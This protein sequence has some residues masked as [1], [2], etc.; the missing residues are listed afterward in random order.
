[1]VQSLCL[2]LN[3]KLVVTPNHSI[4]SLIRPLFSVFLF[5]G[6]KKGLDQFTGIIRPGIPRTG[7]RYFKVKCKMLSSL[8]L[9]HIMD[10]TKTGKLA[11]K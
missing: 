6:R 9:V 1:M 3:A 2:I 8:I 5:G 4:V 7:E 11:Y 10:N